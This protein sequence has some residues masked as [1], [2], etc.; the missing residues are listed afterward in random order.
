[1]YNP[2]CEACPHHLRACT[3]CV[4]GEGPL[5][6]DLMIVGMNPG[7]LEDLR[8][9]PFIG[10]AGQIL[11][12][13]LATAGI[14]RRSAYVTNAVKCYSG[15]AKPTRT[16]LATCSDLYLREEIARVR[17]RVIVAMGDLAMLALT[18]LSGVNK[19]R[20]HLLALRPGLAVT[21]G[22]VVVPTY[23]P[24]AYLHAGRDE[25]IKQAITADLRVARDALEGKK[26]YILEVREGEPS[27]GTS[28]F[29]IETGPEGRFLLG[30][31]ADAG[32]TYKALGPSTL[33][34]GGSYIAWNAKFD[35]KVAEAAG[36]QVPQVV[37]DPMLMLHLLDSGRRGRYGLEQ[38]VIDEFGAA[39]PTWL[40]AKRRVHHG[41]QLPLDELTRYCAQ[42]SC[43]TARL[44][45]RF[46][47]RLQAQPALLALY[48]HL[49]LPAMRLLVQVEQTPVPLDV[50]YI[51]RLDGELAERIAIVEAEL[52]DLAGLDELPNFRSHKILVDVLYKRLGLP[53]LRVTDSGAPSTAKAVLMDLR[54]LSPFV[55]KLL[56][57][58]RLGKQR[59][60]YTRRW[61]KLLGAE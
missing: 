45:E 24:A 41:E 2:S 17:P 25:R 8:G 56:E 4:P 5:D 31:I 43:Y 35:I 51:R 58:K 15:K 1:V 40:E 30:T 19:N 49:V 21:A 54:R 10:P 9:R 14:D 44:F 48:E 26:P 16:E 52:A 29:D 3:V 18:N 11:D 33:A 7:A 13:A 42:D 55:S 38:A 37:H 6:A 60:S 36:Y 12:E 53:I 20:G 23:H 27:E 22:V 50:D 32:G 34:V 59:S 46:Y 47:P 39:D 28:A 57:F 61:L